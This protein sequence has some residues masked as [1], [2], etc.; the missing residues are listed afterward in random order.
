MYR[1][2][3]SACKRGSDHSRLPAER[4]SQERLHHLEAP[5]GR[6]AD[7][8]RGRSHL[9]R[10]HDETERPLEQHLLHPIKEPMNRCRRWISGK[11]RNHYASASFDTNFLHGSTS[12]TARARRL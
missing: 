9:G 10:V 1:R 7:R 5:S 8:N 4:T 11:M 2:Q 6:V 3:S 12:T